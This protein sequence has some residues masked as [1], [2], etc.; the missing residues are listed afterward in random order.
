MAH[1]L[2]LRTQTPPNAKGNRKGPHK[3]HRLQGRVGNSGQPTNGQIPLQGTTEWPLEALGTENPFDTELFE[4]IGFG[5]FRR[6]R[7]PSAD[8]QE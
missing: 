5:G 4:E 8:E 2:R 6:R 1:M 3:R 7:L